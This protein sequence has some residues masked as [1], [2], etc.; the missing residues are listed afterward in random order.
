MKEIYI[1]MINDLKILLQRLEKDSKR[2]IFFRI[3]YIIFSLLFLYFCI[4][5][6]KPSYFI[7]MMFSFILFAFSV[8]KHNKVKEKINLINCKINVINKYL[9][10]IDGSWIDFKEDGSDLYKNEDYLSKDLD[11]LGKY[12]LFQ[13]INVGYTKKG[14]ENLY[15]LFHNNSFNIEE[16]INRQNIVKELSRNIDFS[17]D[18]QTLLFLNSQK[19]KK[20]I[21]DALSAFLKDLD[22]EIKKYPILNFYQLV[23]LG[24]FICCAFNVFEL[25]S[26]SIAMLTFL[27]NLLIMNFVGHKYQALVQSI[28]VFSNQLE[29]YRDLFELIQNQD[30]NNSYLKSIVCL[31]K[32]E[33]IHGMNGLCKINSKLKFRY[34][35][36]ANLLLNGILLYDLNCMSELIKWKECYKDNISQW[37]DVIFDLEALLSLAVIENTRDDICYPEVCKEMNVLD[38]ED[39]KHPL[40]EQ[41]NAVGNMFN[42]KARTNIVTG[43]NMSGKT[44]FL[45]TIGINALLAYA[46]APV[47][48]KRMNITLMYVLTSMRVEDDLTSSTS[49]FYAELKRIK[50]MIEFS[51][52]KQPM[53]C[54][55]DEIFKGTNSADRI[56]GAKA[57]IEKLN[58]KYIITFVSTH[59]FELCDLEKIN[60]LSVNNYHFKE[61]YINKQIHFDYKLCQG[62]CLTTNARY[63][64]EMVGIL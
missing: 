34:N 63:L 42:L 1:S 21:N 19:S 7:L 35:V 31:F 9:K 46:G 50:A 22:V 32:E 5:D 52:N 10:R 4:I 64:L 44:T 30:F 36:V 17:I 38:F 55:I 28:H 48:A 29:T 59:D 8:F 2:F 45:R 27:I 20:D 51:K 15:S 6:L 39:L 33:A 25:A 16:I 14:K 23:S 18:F 56:V 49:T 12:S 37:F 41:N 40:I 47:V 57:A 24:I 13:Y 3:V 43:S 26:G 58:E 60:G 53:L 54:L 11:L 62:R 61:D